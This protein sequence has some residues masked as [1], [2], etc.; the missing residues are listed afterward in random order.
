VLSRFSLAL[1]VAALVL[2]CADP[3]T[4]QV[5]QQPSQTAGLRL[6]TTLFATAAAADWATT[7][8]GIKHYQL[9]ETNPLIR[10]FERTPAKMVLLGAA[11]DVGAVAAWNYTVGRKHPRVAA[12]GLWTMTAFRAYLAFHNSRNMQRSQRR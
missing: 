12:A 10:K 1:I 6:P 7:Y 3:A 4:A 11:I 9:R 2:L 8:Y 5:E